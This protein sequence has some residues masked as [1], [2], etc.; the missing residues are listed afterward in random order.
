L[1]ELLER[2]QERVAVQ[3]GEIALDDEDHAATLRGSAAK[4]NGQNF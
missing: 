3:T 4:R 1:L 2:A